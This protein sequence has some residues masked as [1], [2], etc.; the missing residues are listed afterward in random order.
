MQ[1]EDLRSVKINM[2]VDKIDYGNAIC[3]YTGETIK[4]TRYGGRIELKNGTTFDFMSTECTA[5]FYINYDKKDE[6]AQIKITDFAHGV[7]LLPVDQ[8]LYLRS[9]LR[10]SPNGL[11]LTAVESSNLKMLEYISDAY[12]GEY[13]TWDEVLKIVQN[14]MDLESHKANSSLRK[15][16]AE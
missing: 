15:N 16:R 11:F 4:T 1:T 10:P 13:V 9:P 5:A 7:Q 8:L 14:E 6:I 2:N 12:P 3:A